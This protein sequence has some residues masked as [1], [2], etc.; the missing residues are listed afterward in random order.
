MG[1]HLHVGD[2]QQ[3]GELGAAVDQAV[4]VQQV[5]S[6]GSRE[7]GLYWCLAGA[8]GTLPAPN[9]HRQAGCMAHATLTRL[10]TS[11]QISSTLGH[12][13]EP[14]PAFGDLRL[15]LPH[16]PRNRDKVPSVPSGSTPRVAGRCLPAHAQVL[17]REPVLALR[18]GCD[19]EVGQGLLPPEGTSVPRGY[20]GLTAPGSEMPQVRAA[21]GH[22]RPP[23]TSSSASWQHSLPSQ[24]PLPD[25]Q[26]LRFQ[27]HL[28]HCP[29]SLALLCSH[30]VEEPPPLH[31]H[32]RELQLWGQSSG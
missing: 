1:T 29:P 5:H 23:A 22:P 27:L 13:A 15:L 14:A 25:L 18:L 4:P 19:A 8:G 20:G 16:R 17:A 30:L 32:L 28:Q 7:P 6:A 2:E 11:A 9:P 24:T 26:L 10:V 12:C 31:Q 21:V 3:L